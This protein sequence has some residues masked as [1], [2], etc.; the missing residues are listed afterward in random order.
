MNVSVLWNFNWSI[1]TSPHK[2]FRDMR[3]FSNPN[4]RSILVC[5]VLDT[6]P[7]AN[8]TEILQGFNWNHFS[9]IL[10]NLP[11]NIFYVPYPGFKETAYAYAISAAGVVSQVART[12]SMGKLESCGCQ[13]HLDH[14]TNTWK[15][16]GCNH[17]VEFGHNFARKFLDFKEGAKDL[18][19]H[20]NLHNNRAGRL[21]SI[22]IAY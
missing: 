20:M 2:T 16:K 6:K 4:F 17:N 7:E 12:C 3:I 21:V 13:P 5:F 1:L 10:R 22:T 11:E 18:H 14:K 8:K 15:W 9:F 19:S